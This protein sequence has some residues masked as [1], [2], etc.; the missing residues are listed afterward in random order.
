MSNKPD[1]VSSSRERGQELL[2]YQFSPRDLEQLKSMA[3]QHY[4]DNAGSS[5]ARSWVAAVDLY[6]KQLQASL[7]FESP[8]MGK[9]S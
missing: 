4:L 1:S 9:E 5:M 7:V 3:M 6:L 8:K 2:G